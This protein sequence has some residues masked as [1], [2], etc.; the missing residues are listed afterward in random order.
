MG[1]LGLS[2]SCSVQIKDEQWCAPIPGDM[3]AV[4]DNFLTSNQ[5][6][7][8]EQ[9][10]LDLQASWVAQGEVTECTSSQTLGDVKAEL[11][12]LC[13]ATKCDYQTQQAVSG[14]KKLLELR[15]QARVL[16]PN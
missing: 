7:L 2:S 15:D 5:K 8:V 9:E 13:S 14:V 6:L 16:M 12:K 11:E 1:A 10:W 4:C 3:G